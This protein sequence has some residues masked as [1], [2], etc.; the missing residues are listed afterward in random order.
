M[1]L[2]AHDLACLHLRSSQPASVTSTIEVGAGVNP[3]R[4]RR[5]TGANFPATSCLGA[6]R[7]PTAS[8]RGGSRHAGVRET[9]TIAAF[10]VKSHST[11]RDPDWCLPRLGNRESRQR[12]LRAG[13]IRC[14]CPLLRLRISRDVANPRTAVARESSSLVIDG[15][16]AINRRR[17][18]LVAC[19]QLQRKE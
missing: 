6:S 8:V 7:T 11:L 9:Y 3:H 1:P 17:D 16:Q 19:F 10:R 12:R 18:T 15:L 2:Y 4:T 14:L 5:P 13:P